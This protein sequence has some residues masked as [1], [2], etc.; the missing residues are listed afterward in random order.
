MQR[1]MILGKIKNVSGSFFRRLH[2]GERIGQASAA[3]CRGAAENDRRGSSVNIK[4]PEG[5]RT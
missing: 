1:F 4:I 5:G 2:P 3:H